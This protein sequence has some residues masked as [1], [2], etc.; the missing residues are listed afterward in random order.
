MTKRNTQLKSLNI[1]GIITAT[2]DKQS[3][4]FVSKNPRK[5]IYVKLDKENQEKAEQFGLTGYV[6]QEDQVR[7]YP[8]KASA[9]I[10]LYK[11]GQ[12]DSFAKISGIADES[13]N[14]HSDGKEVRLAL[15]KGRNVGNDF[16]RLTAIQVVDE[17]DIQEVEQT[18]PFENDDAGDFTSF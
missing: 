13:P 11:L 5:T 7:F 15:I 6:S 3:K 14:F 12:K 18:N 17:N 4:D 16:F 10:S 8:I 1:N 9:D 2:S